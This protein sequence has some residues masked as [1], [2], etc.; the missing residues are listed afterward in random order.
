MSR[1]MKDQR[2]L[3]FVSVRFAIQLTARPVAGPFGTGV[4]I[5]WLVKDGVVM[6]AHNGGDFSFDN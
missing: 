2:W 6:I 3:A 5:G 4:E 1:P